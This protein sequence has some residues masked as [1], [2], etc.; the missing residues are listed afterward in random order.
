MDFIIQN[1]ALSVEI[2][3]LGAELQ[4]IKSAD[5]KEY[6]WQAD[7][8]YWGERAPNLFPYVGRL[9]Q[10][11]YTLKGKIYEM[12]IHGFLKRK[13]LI[14]EAQSR[15]SV[16]FRLDSDEETRNCY[17]FEF[18][19][20]IC[21]TLRRNILAVTSTVENIGDERMYFALGAH[22][23]FQVPL[24]EELT[25]ED[26]CLEFPYP[27]RP[28]RVLLSDTCYCSG[29]EREYPLE[30][31]KKIRLSHDLFDQ[32][33]LILRHVPDS[34]R[35]ASDKG[36]RSVTVRYPQ[37]PYLGIWHAVKKD[38]PYVCIEPWTSL[39]SRDGIVEDLSCQSDLIRLNRGE[40]YENSWE[41]EII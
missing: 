8:A 5:G 37:F 31:G 25:F 28:N 35:I 13:R 24:E 27:S 15:Q 2:S 4:S 32:D 21:Y 23:G 34:V 41:I 40:T 19:Y 33:A 20:W 7:P 26:Y 29:T 22:P 3:D 16:T 17:P 14:P 6:L 36:R 9:T 38:A 1:E 39:P 30:E 10:G 12:P 18:L 11:R